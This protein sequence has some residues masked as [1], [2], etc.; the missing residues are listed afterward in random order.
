MAQTTRKSFD[1]ADEVRKFEGGTGQVELVNLEGGGT[2]GRSTHRPGW[3][4]SEHVKPIV[5]TDSCDKAHVG[6][7]VSGAM[8]VRTDDGDEVAVRAGD[9]V[10]I[11]PG[12]D[13]WVDG[14]E[15]CVVIDWVGMGDY[16]K[17]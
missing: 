10:H 2:V 15:A 1:Q 7:V 14:D 4:W 11:P 16:A 6:Y 17:G 13:A 9:F 8:T 12:H 3:R 5:G